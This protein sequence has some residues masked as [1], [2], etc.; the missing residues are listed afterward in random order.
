MWDDDVVA[1]DI[2]LALA[3]VVAPLCA[4]A[5]AK[6]N[7]F[8]AS[9]LTLL[10]LVATARLVAIAVG[11]AGSGDIGLALVVMFLDVILASL[12][13]AFLLSVVG[14]LL[15]R[16]MRRERSVLAS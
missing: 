6:R 1:L 9:L 4:V 8:W 13:T 15:W 12:A 16:W 5:W 7:V 2:S 14:V 11:H 10:A 3:A